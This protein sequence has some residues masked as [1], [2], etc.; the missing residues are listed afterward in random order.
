MEL[1]QIVKPISGI[2]LWS[3]YRHTHIKNQ[4]EVLFPCYC[5]AQNYQEALRY[6]GRLPFEQAETN[7]K[8]YGKTLMHHVPESTTVL[9]KRLCTNYEPIQDSTDQDSVDK[10]AV[11]KVMIPAS[12]SSF[13]LR[14]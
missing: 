3:G 10:L 1:N 13:I 4:T 7:M 14:Q 2:E 9:L 5:C 8:H 6:I 11:N 12:L